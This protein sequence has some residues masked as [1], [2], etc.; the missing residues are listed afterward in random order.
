MTEPDLLSVP[1][2]LWKR[3][4]W[5]VL[6]AL[7][8]FVGGYLAWKLLA[9]KYRASTMILV[10]SQKVPTDYV[11]TTV[12]SSLAERLRTIQQQITN[13][14]NLERIILEL[15]L[16]PEYRAVA[17]MEDVVAHARRALRVRVERGAT[18]R[19]SYRGADPVEVARAANRI[20]ELFIEENLKVRE[21]QAER[22]SQFL[23]TELEEIRSRL[24]TQEEAVAQFRLRHEGE[25]PE[26]R[27][28]NLVAVT[29]LEAELA[30]NREAF[31][32][33]ELR[34]LLL[35]NQLR[36]RD[37]EIVPPETSLSRLDEL[38][39][40]LAQL[41][42][43]FTDRH[44]DVVRLQREIAELE[45][46][47]TEPA[48]VEEM[49][50]PSATD[51]YA[52]AEIRALDRELVRLESERDQILKEIG[53]FERRLERTPRVQQGLLILTRDYDNLRES[54]EKLLG[55][56]LEARL[57]E[58]LERSQQGEQFRILERAVPPSRPYFP[59]RTICLG[60]G[61]LI[62]LA[63]GVGAAFLREEVD[64]TFGDPQSLQSAFPEVTV[65][66]SI[67]LIRPK[68]D[69]P[70]GSG[71]KEKKSA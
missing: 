17:P 38:K 19:V 63:L 55:K 13:R 3:K 39:L 58:N 56:R 4:H 20:A 27:D 35:E 49:P 29:R 67:P 47:A 62:G 65:L 25:L 2:I 60:G 66:T 41:R 28:S 40:E 48:G 10:E 16:Y 68:W 61:L 59:Q 64:Q 32:Q 14:E 23:E 37:A 54:Y 22:T 69:G 6:L 51:I 34:K 42:S 11:K 52:A 7:L 24:E 53:R 44:P 18:F 8:G 45:T 9:P 43:R 15:D 36:S 46:Q 5:V 12:T 26:Q 1:R 31:Q 33:A 50:L 71:W 57:A 21:G 30:A 70:V